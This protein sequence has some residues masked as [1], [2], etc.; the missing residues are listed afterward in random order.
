MSFGENLQYLRTEQGLTQEQ[1]AERLE[2]SRQSVSKWESDGSFPEME[3]L[4]AL[5][6]LFRCSLD[7]LLRGDVKAAR[8][9]D[10]AGYDRH[11]NHFTR[12]I[13]TG[14]SLCICG[15]SAAALMEPF[16]GDERWS[17]VLFLTFVLVA[18]VF[19]IVGGIQHHD[20]CE[21]NPH[22]EPFYDEKVLAAWR[23]RF[24]VFIAGGIAVCIG[25]IILMALMGGV[26]LGGLSPQKSEDLVGGFGLLLIAA[27]VGLL[28]YGG[29]QNDKYHITEYNRERENEKSPQS[30]RLS[31]IYGAIMLAATGV[32]L[33]Y[34]Y[35]WKMHSW[36]AGRYHGLG[37]G[38]ALIFG[39]GGLLCGIINQ[40]FSR[41]RKDK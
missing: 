21:H 4:L 5:C 20:F 10:S 6:D 23:Q 18:V 22:I 36:D 3:K 35:F 26:S 38:A 17:G 40:L 1:L 28:V 33:T 37:F 39:L 14:V 34:W 31:H 16:S 11:M 13:T 19:F 2:V 32:F 24:P 8:Q 25:G 7:T 27:G 9:A 29:M 30:R 41:E 12:M 15:F